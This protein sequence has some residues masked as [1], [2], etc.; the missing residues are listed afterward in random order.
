VENI[1]RVFRQYLSRGQ[2]AF[3]EKRDVPPKEV[4]DRV[5]AAGGVV[6]LAHPGRVHGPDEVKR[7]AAEGLDGVEVMHPANRATTRSTMNAVAA[8]LGLLRSGGSDW[9]GPSTHRKADV[10]AEPVPER[11]FDEI[12]RRAPAMDDEALAGC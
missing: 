10:G 12:W 6:I 2:P 5:H 9:H 3:V 7:W 8:E 4:F 11:W 1:H